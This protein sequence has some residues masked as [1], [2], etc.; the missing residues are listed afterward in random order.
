MRP[1]R[2]MGAI[3]P[4]KT[5]KARSVMKRDGTKP[6]R[7]LNKGGLPDLEAF[8]TK[9]PVRELPKGPPRTPVPGG[10]GQTPKAD[11]SDQLRQ[12]REQMGKAKGGWIQKAIKRP[13]AFTAK[14]KAAGKSVAAFA[15][16]KASAPG[17]LGKQARLAQTLGKMRK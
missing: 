16:E 15:K 3:A 8:R 13:G 6:V 10:D 11:R 14:A 2:G 5:P 4:S 9:I 12:L 17:R 7:L 1:S